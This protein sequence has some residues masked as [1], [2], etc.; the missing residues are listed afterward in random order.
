M[1]LGPIGAHTVPFRLIVSLLYRPAAPAWGDCHHLRWV[2]WR[3]DPWAAWLWRRTVDSTALVPARRVPASAED[4]LRT[5]GSRSGGAPRDRRTLARSLRN[6][7]R[8][9]RIPPCG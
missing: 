9:H 6:H 4:P 2:R 7:G 1:G 8:R 5:G 3:S